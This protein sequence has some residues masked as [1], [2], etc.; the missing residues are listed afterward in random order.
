MPGCCAGLFERR[1]LAG[2][3]QDDGAAAA[4]LERSSPALGEVSRVD[5]GELLPLARQV[6]FREDRGDR[7]GI[8]AQSAIDA[9]GGIDVELRIGVLA[10]DAIDWANVDAGLVLDVDAGFGDDVGHG[11]LERA[12]GVDEGRRVAA[13]C[14][15]VTD[16]CDSQ[17][18]LS[19]C[20]CCADMAVGT[21]GRR[22]DMVRVQGLEP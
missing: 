13:T 5:L 2:R 10:V 14:A 9:V 7:A 17:W 11:F 18:L 20:C 1:A 8:H 21:H 3:Q 16:A 19:R 15:A 4:I 12:R 22:K 6:F